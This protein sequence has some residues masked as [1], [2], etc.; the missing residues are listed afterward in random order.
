MVT[1]SNSNNR[2]LFLVIAISAIFKELKGSAPL[3]VIVF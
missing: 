2:R 1:F 3:I